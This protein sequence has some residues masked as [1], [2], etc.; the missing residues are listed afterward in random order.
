MTLA[1]Q[2]VLITGASRGIGWSI[3]RQ[4]AEAGAAVALVARSGQRVE[5]LA[6]ELGG[7]AYVADLSRCD[8]VGELIARVES[9]GPVDI[10]VNNAARAATAGLM[11]LTPQDVV[12]LTQ[13]NLATP[14]ELCR[15]IVPGM[16]ERGGGHVVN[17]SSLAA[18]GVLPGLAVYSATKAAL[19]HF[20]AGLR[21]DLKGH[22]VGV[23]L[24]E[25]DPCG[26]TC[27]PTQCPIRRLHARSLVYAVLVCCRKWIPTRLHATLC[28]RWST[29]AATSDCRDARCCFQSS[30]RHL[31]ASLSCSWSAHRSRGF[32][33][34]DRD[35][36]PINGAEWSGSGVTSAYRPWQPERETKL[37]LPRIICTRA[38][39]VLAH[40]VRPV[41]DISTVWAPVPGIAVRPS[42]SYEPCLCLGIAVGLD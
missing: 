15:R 34:P 21:A 38:S 29:N 25:L 17:I 16:I 22:P 24:V 18:T 23:T 37:I 41:G 1:G 6:Q 28:E 32:L 27:G 33:A 26:R 30:A 13:L 39:H 20:S 10:L 42:R 4:C 5:R 7:T 11:A 3:A 14:I 9:D 31:V 2:R 8:Q 35:C 19:S 12:E 40:V 36:E